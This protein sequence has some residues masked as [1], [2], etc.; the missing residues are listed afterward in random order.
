MESTLAAHATTTSSK[1]TILNVRENGER[2]LRRSS[3]F[4]IY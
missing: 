3:A 4:R 2:S 1:Q